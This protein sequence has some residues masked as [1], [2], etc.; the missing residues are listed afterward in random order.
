MEGQSPQQPNQ[1]S[2]QQKQIYQ[3]SAKSWFDSHPLPLLPHK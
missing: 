3:E 1:T 2:G